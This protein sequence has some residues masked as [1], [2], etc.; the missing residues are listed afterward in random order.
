MPASNPT[1]GK[2]SDR[3]LQEDRV[4]RGRFQF[5]FL[6]AVGGG[7]SHCIAVECVGWFAVNLAFALHGLAHLFLIILF[8]EVY[9]GDGIL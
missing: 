8:C 7:R 2:C 3:N 4:N 5:S 9:L 1:Y 6:A